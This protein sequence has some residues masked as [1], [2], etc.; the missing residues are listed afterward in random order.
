MHEGLVA[1][2]ARVCLVLAW[3]ESALH[4]A[5]AVRHPVSLLVASQAGGVAKLFPTLA[6]A[7]GPGLGAVLGGGRATF[8]ESTYAAAA[9]LLAEG[10]EVGL[11]A[12]AELQADLQVRGGLPQVLLARCV[13]VQELLDVA[14]LML[15]QLRGR[16]EAHVALR[17]GVELI[18]TL[19]DGSGHVLLMLLPL[20][21]LVLAAHFQRVAQGGH[22]GAE[23]GVFGYALS[24]LVDEAMAGQ[25]GAVVELFPTDVAWVDAPL[26]MQPQVAP[27][28]PDR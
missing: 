12:R 10:V 3:R 2:H 27:Q 11:V 24:L 18:R 25:A 5:G 8:T 7:V 4:V 20:A 26:P 16:P 14:H 9:V 21:L 22:V 19:D 28:H 23:G 6:A 13:A 17:A 15:G 1:R